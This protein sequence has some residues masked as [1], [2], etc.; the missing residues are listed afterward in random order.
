MAGSKKKAAVVDETLALHLH[1]FH[2]GTDSRAYEF[3]GARMTTQGRR[4]GVLFRVWAPDAARV[5]VVGD[6]NDWDREKHPMTK[7]SV[8]VWALFVPGVA[9]YAAYKYA[10]ETK[11]GRVLEKADP[12]AFHAETRPRTASKVF[13]LDGYTWGDEAWARAHVSPY[14]RPLNIYEV[15]LGSWR[16]GEDERLLSYDETADRLIPYVKEMGYTHIELMPVMEHPL[17]ASWG[18]QVT[19]YFAP[20]SRFGTPHD[21]M[22]FVDR[23]H[24]AGVGVLLDW[25]PAHFPKDAHGL[26]EFD[27]TYCYEYGDPCKMEHTEWGTRVFD[28]G[29]NEARSFLMSSAL[30]WFDKYHVDGLRVDAVASMLYLDY[31]RKEG[32]WRPNIHGGRENLEAIS[33]LRQLNEQVFASFPHALMIAEESTAWP[34]VTAPTYTGGLGF[35]FKWNMGWMNDALEYAKRDPVFRQYIHN[36]LTFSLM[37]AFSENY[38]LP[39]SH[40]EVVHGKCSLLQKMPGYYDDKFAGVRAFL[41]YMMTHPGKK[42]HFMGSELGQF[43]EWN[44]AHSLDWHLLEY[45]AHKKL[46][47]YVKA[48]NHFYLACPALWERDCTQAGFDWLNHGDYQG[49]TLAYRRL[50][51]SG[52]ELVAAFNFSPMLKEGYR[53]GVPAPGRYREI[54]N[55]DDADFGGWGH[56]NPCDLHTE[57]AEWLGRP[58]V[59]TFTLPPFGAVFLRREE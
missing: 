14:S 35:N 2:E 11:Q 49:N 9:A 33:F 21:F 37:Y 57:D 51:A 42:L 40:D 6:F 32:A 13:T 56:K 7:I 50:D 58:Y 18:Y 26:V 41:A 19:G 48:L 28:Y 47:T 45:D 10:I 24:Q 46:H 29:R 27:G 38:I 15:H 20:T 4:R 44:F 25:V 39:V 1:L 43:I 12:Y 55:S 54:L 30:F 23:C 17:D 36:N 5:S 16:R 52:G 34:M 3:L 22:R 59:L 8:G 53:L 31:A